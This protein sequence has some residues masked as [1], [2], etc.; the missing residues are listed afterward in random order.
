MIE[1]LALAVFLAV[2]S[3]LAWSPSRRR[4]VV[5]RLSHN[6]EK[7]TNPLSAH[8]SEKTSTLGVE[9]R[10]PLPTPLDITPEQVATYDDRPWRPF[11]WPYH[12]T[13]SIFKLDINHWIDMDK[14]Y[15]RYLQEKQQ[16]NEKN[17]TA[18]CDWL[19]ESELACQEL[20]DTVVEHLVHRYPKLFTMTGISTVV[21]HVTKETIDLKADHPLHLLSKLTKEDYYVVQKRDD[22]R[23]Y[24]VAAEVPFP[25]GSFSIQTK[26]GKHLNVIHEPVP[27]YKEKLMPSM[28]RYFGRMKVNEPVERASWYVSW[29]YNLDVSHVYND[30]HTEETVRQVPYEN[31]VVRVERQTLRRLPKSRAIIFT[32]HP[33]YYKIC[34]MKDEPFVP[35]IIKKVMFEAP[36]DIIKYKNYPMIRDYLVVYLDQ[37]IERQIE[38][39]IIKR[40]D[41]IRTSPNYPF[42]H[43]IT[44]PFVNSSER[45]DVTN[46]PE[47]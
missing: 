22:G 11:R 31:F 37:L 17:G 1:Y 2:V 43:F 12:Q 21:N 33:V 8:L 28:E 9:E 16:L 35:S 42:A 5:R 36:E 4:T 18:A 10:C 3:V 46:K 40:D 7:G 34:D 39:G 41:P 25:G 30:K 15:V 45:V 44:K 29:D 27:Y 23:H 13:M 38:M 14:W 26:I 20:L 19:P 6:L 24:L 32:N 47:A